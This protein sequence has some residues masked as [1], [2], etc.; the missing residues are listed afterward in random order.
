MAKL[1]TVNGGMLG[2][3]F[4]HEPPLGGLFPNRKQAE[5]W[6]RYYGLPGYEHNT[7]VVML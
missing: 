5:N 4:K 2:E 7:K 6:A 1:V 3:F